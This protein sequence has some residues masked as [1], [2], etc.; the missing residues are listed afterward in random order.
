MTMRMDDPSKAHK[1]KR[2]A[3]IRLAAMIAANVGAICLAIMFLIGSQG[4]IGLLIVF[5]V[6]ISIG[7]LWK[8]RALRRRRAQTIVQQ[9]SNIER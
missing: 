2:D 7:A 6:L 3:R 9:N 1:P 5:A 8:I 4:S